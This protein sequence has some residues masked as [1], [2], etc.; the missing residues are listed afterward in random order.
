M[1]RDEVDAP[2][3]RPGKTPRSRVA[4]VTTRPSRVG[5]AYGETEASHRADSVPAPNAVETGVGE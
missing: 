5:R 1:R 4:A 2:P 3:G